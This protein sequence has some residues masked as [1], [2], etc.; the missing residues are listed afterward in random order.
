MAKNQDAILM[1]LDVSSR[2]GFFDRLAG[3]VARVASQAPFFAFCALLVVLWLAQGVV[4]LL[5]G[6][7]GRR[8]RPRRISWR[9]TPRRRSSRFCSSR[10]CRTARLAT[11]TPRSTS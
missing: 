1:P 2:V 4:E 7:A 10:S 8:S 9:S 3:A 5:T 11:T 6:A